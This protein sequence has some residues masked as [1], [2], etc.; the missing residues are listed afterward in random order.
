MINNNH[1]PTAPTL[2]PKGHVPNG[3]GCPIG[4]GGVNIGV[5]WFYQPKIITDSPSLNSLNNN[6]SS[7]KSTTENNTVSNRDSIDL[8][9]IEDEDHS[10]AAFFIGMKT[11]PSP[12]VKRPL[13]CSYHYIKKKFSK[14]LKA[15]LLLI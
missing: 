11:G 10:F 5:T 3:T 15:I 7:S 13:V 8:I 4:G 6:R 9:D 2:A 14:F 12:Y 1:C